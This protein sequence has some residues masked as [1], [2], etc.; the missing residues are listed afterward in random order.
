MTEESVRKTDKT[1]ASYAGNL[2]EK[3]KIAVESV[4]KAGKT[5]AS[6]AGNLSERRKIAVGSVRKAE[7]TA[8]SYAGNLS[9]RRKMAEESV[10]KAD[11]QRHRIQAISLKGERC[12]R[13]AYAKQ[14]KQHLRMKSSVPRLFDRVWICGLYCL[15][16]VKKVTASQ[17]VDG[18]AETGKDGGYR[19]CAG[20]SAGRSEGG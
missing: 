18:R 11:K 15:K 1:A 10:R 2:S 6:Y 3:R 5:A 8:A 13:K 17:P 7:K 14:K 19:L 20:Q 9:E 4:R 16:K 12:Q